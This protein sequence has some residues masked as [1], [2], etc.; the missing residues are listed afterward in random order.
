MA[1]LVIPGRAAPVANLARRIGRE[2]LYARPYTEIADGR[3]WGVMPPRMIK[4]DHS[5]WG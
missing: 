5:T 3:V 4:R 2:G 1:R